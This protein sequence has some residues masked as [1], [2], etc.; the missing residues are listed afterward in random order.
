MRRLPILLLAAAVACALSGCADYI[1]INDLIIV[2]G[3]GLD[4]VDGRFQATLEVVTISSDK[5]SKENTKILSG[6]GVDIGAALYSC[7]GKNVGTLYLD[8]CR[9]VV[10]GEETARAGISDVVAFMRENKSLLSTAILLVARDMTAGELLRLTPPSGTVLSF[11][12]GNLL[13]ATYPGRM[14]VA[15]RSAMELGSSLEK[16]GPGV[17][18]PALSADDVEGSTPVLEGLALF[19][20]STC[21]GFLDT[22]EAALVSLLHGAPKDMVLSLPGTDGQAGISALVKSGRATLTPRFTGERPRLHIALSAQAEPAAFPADS[23]WSQ[24]ALD[25]AFSRQLTLNLEDLLEKLQTTLHSDVIGA[26]DA[27]A[28]IPRAWAQGTLTDWASLFPEIEILPSAEV[29]LERASLTG[30][31]D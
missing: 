3:I 18:A 15:L 31:V 4:R 23:P 21:A 13:F 8:H 30:Q 10:V 26:F 5:N 2:A 24:A 27:F 1:R 25:E 7:A 20:R 12:L 29:R 19:D 28:R 22:G 14:S 6:E 17:F 16:P 11:D 9:T